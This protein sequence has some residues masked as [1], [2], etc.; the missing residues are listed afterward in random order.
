MPL[1]LCYHGARTPNANGFSDGNLTW[2]DLHL[3]PFKSVTNVL[4]QPKA[5]DIFQSYESVFIQAKTISNQR[6]RGISSHPAKGF[7]FW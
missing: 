1:S 2:H 5:G 6:W 3:S 7:N 4:I